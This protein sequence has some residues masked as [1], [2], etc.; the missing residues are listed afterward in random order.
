MGG[1]SRS[2]RCEQF[3]QAHDSWFLFLKSVF[4][5][6]VGHAVHA[7]PGLLVVQI[8]VVLFRSRDVPLGE[9]VA[10]ESREVHDVDILNLCIFLK[11]SDQS[12]KDSRLYL[13]FTSRL[14]WHC[15]ISIQNVR[16]RNLRI[17]VQ[18]NCITAI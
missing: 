17:D 16:N 14:G 4:P 5:G 11:V 7:F 13:S 12:P 1:K 10:T 9:A 2:E 18:T 8:N 3:C 15:L 6:T